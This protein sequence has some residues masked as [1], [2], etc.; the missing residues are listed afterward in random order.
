MNFVILL[1]I[2][3]IKFKKGLNFLCFIEKL[4][5]IENDDIFFEVLKFLFPCGFMCF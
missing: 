5:W 4:L 3:R 1:L 2:E